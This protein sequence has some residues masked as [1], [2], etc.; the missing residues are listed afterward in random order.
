MCFRFL[1]IFYCFILSSMIWIT[2]QLALL[3]LVLNCLVQYAAPVPGR[4]NETLSPTTK[5]KPKATPTVKPPNTR[6]KQQ[7]AKPTAKPSATTRRHTEK[8]AAVLTPLKEFSLEEILFIGRQSSKWIVASVFVNKDRW[9]CRGTQRAVC[10]SL[11]LFPTGIL[12]A[13]KIVGV[14]MSWL[15]NCLLLKASA[16]N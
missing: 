12:L 15:G 1:S 10:S 7:T 14:P 9:E 16:W 13:G 3:L 8:K 2:A 11:H 6:A 4:K 5:R